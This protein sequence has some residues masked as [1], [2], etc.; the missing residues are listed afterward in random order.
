MKAINYLMEELVFQHERLPFL[1]PVLTLALGV[2]AGKT[3]S[4]A[5]LWTCSVVYF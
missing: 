3:K 2:V 5:Q 1:V 4:T